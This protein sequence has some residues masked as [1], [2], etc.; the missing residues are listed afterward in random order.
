MLPIQPEWR[1][2]LEASQHTEEQEALSEMTREYDEWFLPYWNIFHEVRQDRR[3]YG[4]RHP[5]SAS[6]ARA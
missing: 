3:S 1:A 5:D 4:T 6:V 2:Q